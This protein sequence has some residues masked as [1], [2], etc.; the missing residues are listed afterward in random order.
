MDSRLQCISAQLKETDKEIS[1]LEWEGG[2]P[3]KLQALYLLR[4]H[5]Q[6][7]LQKGD[8]YIPNF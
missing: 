7:L 6:Y 4:E 5:L 1:D 8:S 2:C 3:D